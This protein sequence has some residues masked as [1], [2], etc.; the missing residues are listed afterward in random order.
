MAK[1]TRSSITK[2]NRAKLRSTVFGPVSDARTARLSAKLEEIA[3]Q[4]RPEV[5]QKK[6]PI[7]SAATETENMDIDTKTSGKLTNANSQKSRRVQKRNKKARNSIVFQ[8]HPSKAKRISK[9]K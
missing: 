6:S 1:S 9:K 3:A 2:R 5:D 7:E 4:P 8:Q